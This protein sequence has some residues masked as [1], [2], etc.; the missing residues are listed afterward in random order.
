M[1]AND[2]DIDFDFEKEYGID[3]PALPKDLEEDD[4]F[5]LTAVLDAEYG[6]DL[7]AENAE[8]TDDFDYGLDALLGEDP[9]EVPAPLPEEEV[10]PAPAEPAEPAPAEAV[11]ED[12]TAPIPQIP[13][14]KPI[15]KLRKFKNDTLPLL[16]GAATVILLLVFIIGSIT[17]ASL[18]FIRT[19]SPA[20]STCT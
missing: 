1:N 15:S 7:P 9:T 8:N 10:V 11:T 6:A 19:I 5:D 18:I 17:A 4:D 14:R 13:R 3:P 12:T 20:V 16:I 2:F